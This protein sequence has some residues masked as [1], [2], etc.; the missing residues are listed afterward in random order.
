M[1]N[2]DSYIY[3]KLGGSLITKKD[4]PLFAKK[5]LINRL[6]KEIAIYREKKPNSKL[7][8]GHGSGSFGHTT[9]KKYNT[10][11]GVKTTIQ[12]AGF[13]EVWHQARTLNQI[14]M[15]ALFQNQIPAISFDISNFWLCNHKE[16][17]KADVEIIN[18]ILSK[19]IIPVVYGNV[20]LDKTLGGTI[21]STEKIFSVLSKHFLPSRI[22]LAGIEDGIWQDYPK[23]T[24]LIKKITP[25]SLDSNN[26]FLQ[27]S[28][29][30]DVTGGMYSKVETLLPLLKSNQEG[31]IFIFNGLK[32]D[33]VLNALLNNNQDGTFLV[34]DCI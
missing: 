2:T 8:I 17:T 12:W 20:L 11:N 30:T 26:K 4:T 16:P 3:L 27:G 33:S 14:V 10:I 19:N 18:K 21:F 28:A 31:E 22:L 29:N 23:N 34:N 1:T 24:K 32:P 6:A 7:I 13:T 5:E 15:N 9:A 25:K